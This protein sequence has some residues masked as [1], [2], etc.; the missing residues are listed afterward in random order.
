MI[1]TL[2]INFTFYIMTIYYNIHFFNH[3]L[4]VASLSFNQNFLLIFSRHLPFNVPLYVVIGAIL[5]NTYYKGPL[6]Q[7][8]YV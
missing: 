6:Q 8:L 5:I 7:Q 1:R 4:Y 2:Y 3:L